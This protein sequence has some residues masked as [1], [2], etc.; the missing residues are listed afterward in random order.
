MYSPNVSSATK[1]RFVHCNHEHNR[2]TLPHFS[3]EQTF[4]ITYL[5]NSSALTN[6]VTRGLCVGLHYQAA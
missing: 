5:K 2:K 1:E 4:E 3:S 6:V